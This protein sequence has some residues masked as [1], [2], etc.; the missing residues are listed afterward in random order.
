M[1]AD[2]VPA[3]SSIGQDMG[4]T[5]SKE[6][7]KWAQFAS[8]SEFFEHIG[9]PEGDGGRG[10]SDDDIGGES[11]ENGAESEEAAEEDTDEEEDEEPRESGDD[12]IGEGEEEEDEDDQEMPGLMTVTEDSHASDEDEEGEEQGH[13]EGEIDFHIRCIEHSCFNVA[14][15]QCYYYLCTCS[16][17]GS[18]GFPSTTICI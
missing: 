15:M 3:R 5:D 16:N 10:S 14:S 11:D 12:G 4:V 1:S 13:A 18:I 7:K 17:V 2:P 6:D 8:W 9:M